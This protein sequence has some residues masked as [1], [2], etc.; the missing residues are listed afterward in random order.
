VK[1]LK[2]RYS[3]PTAFKRFVIGVDRSRMKLYDVEQTAQDGLADAGKQDNQP[4]QNKFKKKD[5]SG[6]KI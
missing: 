2:N 4:Q 6:F 3:D 1:Q 5:F